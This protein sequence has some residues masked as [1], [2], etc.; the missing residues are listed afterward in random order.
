MVKLFSQGRMNSFGLGHF[1]NNQ[2]NLSSQYTLV[3]LSPSFKNNVALHNPSTW[4]NLNYTILSLSYSGNQNSQ[5]HKNLTNGYSGLSNSL[6]IIPYKKIASIGI[7]ISPYL[8]QMVSLKDSTSMDYYAFDDTL[9]YIKSID[10]YGGIMNFKIGSSIKIK[11]IISLGLSLNYLF[12]SSRQNNL[13]NFGGSSIIKTS[14]F[15]HNATFLNM[16]FQKKIQ[17]KLDLFLNFKHTLKPLNIEIQSKPLFDDVNGNTF[18]DD[19][20]FPYFGDYTSDTVYFEQTHKPSGFGFGVNY[21]FTNNISASIEYINDENNFSLSNDSLFKSLAPVND[22]INNSE[23]LSMSIIKFPR[24]NNLNFIEGVTTRVGITYIKHSMQLDKSLTKEYGASIGL[25]FKFNPVENQ[26]DI[27]Y[28]IGSRNYTRYDEQ[29]LVQ[30]FQIGIS[31]AD[32]W[33]VR[34]RQK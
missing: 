3:T 14:R 13:I 8:N 26:I 9:N 19:F 29:E 24:I 2:G 15:I 31:L 16:F 22:W 12:G 4:H 6:F 10:R 5:Y 33:F 18:Y 30:Q 27:N 1:Y 25:G 34:R 32:L 17:N 7:E 23:K 11:E 20:D 28:Y 21:L